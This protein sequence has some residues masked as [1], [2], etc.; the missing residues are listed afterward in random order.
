MAISEQQADQVYKLCGR[1]VGISS[2]YVL[3]QIPPAKLKKASR[4]Y[5]LPMGQSEVPVLLYDDTVFGSAKEGFMLTN[6]R[7]CG[8][9]IVEKGFFTDIS[10]ISGMSIEHGALSSDVIVQTPTQRIV[11][12]ITQASGKEQKLALFRVL[13]KTIDVLKSPQETRRD[14]NLCANCGAAV[15]PLRALCEYCGRR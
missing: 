9:N 6:R 4:S 7:L 12:Q 1:E 8:K 15:N 2:L 5:A 13:E 10:D 3:E 11:L 14:S